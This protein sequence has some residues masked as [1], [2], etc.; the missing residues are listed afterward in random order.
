MARDV[1]ATCKSADLRKQFPISERETRPNAGVVAV[2][3]F[4]CTGIGGVAVY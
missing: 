2:V 3:I 1:R 4:Q